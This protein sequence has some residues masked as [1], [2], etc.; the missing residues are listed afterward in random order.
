MKANKL[1]EAFVVINSTPQMQ[2]EAFLRNLNN[3][4]NF[5]IDLTVTVFRLPNQERTLKQLENEL[6]MMFIKKLGFWGTMSAVLTG[7]ND[8]S[9]PFDGA[10][11]SVII[12]A[13]V[14][15]GYIN[16]IVS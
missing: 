4:E 14:K 2:V 13:C 1:V 9:G 8:K 3:T 7:L 12:K 10:Q 5:I 6:T 15:M 16:P 11:K